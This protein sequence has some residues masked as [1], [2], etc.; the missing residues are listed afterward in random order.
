[1]GTGS[2]KCLLYVVLIV[3]KLLALVSRIA[4]PAMLESARLSLESIVLMPLRYRAVTLP[5]E[6]PMS[7]FAPGL[8]GGRVEMNM[9]WLVSAFLEKGAE[10]CGVSSVETVHTVNLLLPR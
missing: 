7:V 6:F 4:I 2:G 8:V 10:A 3:E 1:M 5:S 9:Q